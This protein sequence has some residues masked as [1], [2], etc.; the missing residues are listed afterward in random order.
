MGGLSSTDLIYFWGSN[1]KQRSCDGR[2]GGRA[3]PRLAWQWAKKD[4]CAQCTG[5]HA[6]PK[7]TSNNIILLF[8]MDPLYFLAVSSLYGKFLLKKCEFFIRRNFYFTFWSSKTLIWILIR[9]WI[10]L[11]LDQELDFPLNIDPQHRVRPSNLLSVLRIRSRSA[12]P[13]PSTCELLV[14]FF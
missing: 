12:W 8:L 1:K 3:A 2:G 10:H 11:R 6:R 13:C 7:P 9:I 14:K 4:G 5:A